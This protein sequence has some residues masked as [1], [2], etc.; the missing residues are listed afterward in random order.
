[1]AGI[2]GL[3][4][5]L[6]GTIIDN[7]E[8]YME[9]M[10]RRVGGDIG[11]DFGLGHAQELWYSIGAASRDDVIAR[12]GVDPDRFWAVFNRYESLEEKLN[13][14]YL[15]S[16]ARALAGLGLPKGIVTHTTLEHSTRLLELVGMRDHFDPIISCTEDTGFKPSPL[17]LI[18]CV[19]AMR[20]RLDEVL[21][22]GDTASDMMA[23]ADAGIRCAY[24]NRFNRPLPFR[25]DHEIDS[26][27]KILEIIG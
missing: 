8:G 9:L 21:F 25:P 4:F 17:P 5:D 20:L 19:M 22:V 1:M 23:A 13:N 3:I 27:E 26:L 2:K 15:H 11:R 18:Y 7:S 24:I 14:T 10:L 6:D 12:W 16:D